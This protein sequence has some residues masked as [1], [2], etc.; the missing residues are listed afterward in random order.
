MT[1]RPATMLLLLAMQACA[2]PSPVA[3]ECPVI[4]PPPFRLAPALPESPTPL[5]DAWLSSKPGTGK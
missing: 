3:I 2:T 1:Y 4:P 5:L